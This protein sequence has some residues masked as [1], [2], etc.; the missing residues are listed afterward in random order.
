MNIPLELQKAEVP[1][2]LRFN[3]EV[4]KPEVGKPGR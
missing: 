3:A 1:G 2:A 4:E